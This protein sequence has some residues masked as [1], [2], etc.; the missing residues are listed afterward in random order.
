MADLVPLDKPPAVLADRAQQILVDFG[1]TEPPAD[2]AQN[3]IV[4]PDFLRV[5]RRDRADAGPLESALVDPMAAGAA[6]L[7]PHEPARA[8][9]DPSVDDRVA[10]RSAADGHRHDAS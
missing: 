10:H 2:T 6:L 7:V 8:G 4:P 5:G 3:F 1:Y 9:T